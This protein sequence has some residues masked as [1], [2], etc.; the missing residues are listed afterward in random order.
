ML[1]HC[2]SALLNTLCEHELKSKFH[3]SGIVV[4]R[5]SKIILLLVKQREES[6]TSR[7]AKT[8]DIP[9]S[10]SSMARFALPTI[11]AQ[12]FMSIYSM[13]DGLFVSNLVST[14]ALGAVNIVSP[15]LMVILAVGAMLSQGGRA[16]VSA[17]LGAGRHREARENFSLLVVVAFTVSAFLSAVGLLF[18]DPLLSILGANEVLLQ[19]C[20]EYA[21]PIL[22]IIP[23]AM[24]SF[25]ASAFLIAEG[26]PGLGSVL[27]VVGG[28]INVAL[29]YVFIA[30]FQMGIVGAAL[31]TGIGYAVP[32]LIG[33]VF[34]A[35][36]RK[37]NIFLV[38]PKMRIE[39]LVK[40]STNGISE[41]VMMLSGSVCT[42]VMNNV[43]IRLGGADGVAAISIIVYAI[44]ILSAI[45][46]GYDYGVS[47]LAS[48]NFGKHEHT[49]LKSYYRINMGI[50]AVMG[51]VMLVVCVL[52]TDVLV[53]IFARPGTPVYDLATTGLRIVALCFLFM[54]FNDFASSF[55][56]ALNDGKTSGI[57]AFARTFVI[58]IICLIVLPVLW[59]LTG[60]WLAMP[61]A[62]LISLA[63]S[64]YYLHTKKKVYHYA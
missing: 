18:L 45:Y 19:L 1:R 17:Q 53:G 37:G 40:M 39:A 2:V 35:A 64:F 48:Y 24:L 54:G 21:I 52:A 44:S 20:R 10:V 51:V 49:R 13:V 55:F 33:M 46:Y 8:L 34:F 59:G 62:E 4:R 7:M 63:V 36:N 58:S 28:L 61:A 22:I 43:M 38:R 23:V 5:K 12:V 32:A 27:T 25:I 57:I 47:P 42:V 11:F 31:A 30:L 29:D 15:I 50:T 16:L 6:E 3:V 26:R 56:T 60:L 9:I 41:M 14:N